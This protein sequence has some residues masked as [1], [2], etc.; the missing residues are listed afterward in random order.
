MVSQFGKFNL[1][2]LLFWEAE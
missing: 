1:Q 2:T